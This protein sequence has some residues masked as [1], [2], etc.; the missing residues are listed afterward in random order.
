[1]FD[2]PTAATLTELAPT[3]KLRVAVVTAPAKSVVSVVKEASGQL[4]GVPADLAA[5]LAQRLGVDVEFVAAPNTGAIVDAI[6]SGIVEV[7]F[8]PVDD[9][10]RQKLAFGPAYYLMKN[11]YLV[12]AGSDIETLAD[13]DRANIR[14][15]GIDNTTTIR[16]AARLLQNTTIA[17]VK[18]VD[19]AMDLLHSGKV[20]AFAFT[21]DALPPLA[22][23]LPG[24]RILD[25][26]F[27]H[28]DIAIAVPKNRP[29]ALAYV[30]VF[31]EYAEAS[32][33]IR[34]AFDNAD[35]IAPAVAPPSPKRT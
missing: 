33:I 5:A 30:T 9:A 31:M 19:A 35:L 12:R 1:M 26:S 27:Q 20:D 10:R 29:A 4:S 7:G 24:S 22:A 16:N 17:P 8:L 13:V 18:S 6:V 25:G 11:T 32:G 21:H 23:Q 14:V 2:R 15:I 34:R 28:T 3:G